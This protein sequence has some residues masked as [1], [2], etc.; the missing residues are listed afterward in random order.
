[1]TM[2]RQ[3]IRYGLRTLARSPGFAAVVVLILAVGIGVNTAIFSA[4]NAVLLRPLSY[5][6]PSRIVSIWRQEGKESF[7]YFWRPEFRLLREQNQAFES[8]AG[9]SLRRVYLS[10]IDQPRHLHAEEVSPGLFPLL[11][12][13]PVL[14]RGFLPEEE[15]LGKEYVVILSDAFWREQFAGAPDAIGKTLTLDNKSYTIVGVMPPGFRFPFRHPAPFW[16]SMP[17]QERYG[18]GDAPCDILARLPEGSTLEQAQGHMAV[19]TRR[20]VEMDPKMPAYPLVLHRLT[21]DLFGD[22][23]R[24]LLLSFGAAGFLLL[25]ACSNAGNLLLARATLRR[26]EIAI[27]MAV[28]SSRWRILRQMLTESVVLSVAA[29]LLGLLAA[30]CATKGLVG[31]SPGDIPGMRETRVD[32][33]VLLF[34]L[35]TSLLT[36][37]VFGIVPAWKASEVHLIQV[38]KGTLLQTMTGR[39]WRWLHGGLIISQIS[40]SVILLA[41]CGLLVRSLIAMQNADLG[42]QPQ[43]MLRVFIELPKVR[44]PEPRHCK[45]FYEQLLER[46]QHLPGVQAAGL[47]DLGWGIGR[48][49]MEFTVEGRPSASA[50]ET[51]EV[52]GDHVSLGFF[53]SMGMQLLAGRTLTEQDIGDKEVGVVIDEKLARDFFS[54]VNPLGQRIDLDRGRWK[55]TIVGVVKTLRDFD[56]LRPKYGKVYLPPR[57]FYSSIMDLVVRTDGDPMRLAGAVR[58]EISALDKELTASVIQTAGM[59]LSQMLAPQ[60]FHT[61]LIGLSAGIALA[62]A[63][64]GIYGLMAFSTSQRTG[65][66][67]IRM[68]FGASRGD[69]LKAVVG[70]GL[71]LALIGVA[72]GL[73]GALALTR[74]LASLLYDTSTMD[75]LT[76]ALVSVV[77]IVVALLASYLPARRAARIDPMA[78][79]RYE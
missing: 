36:G 4:V 26:R 38:V 39:N 31:L 48:S 78:A 21:D 47:G 76:F 3:D 79:L 75:P 45:A 8:L 62:L 16:L 33:S 7:D 30:F 46:V 22:Y 63:A 56:R 20:L 70:Q 67:G 64:A 37:L 6:E 50:E 77:L 68:A 12:V 69:I 27:R 13:R 2:L 74:V 17:V 15:E 59:A 14:G 65:E 29:G 40:I 57:Q 71:K 9:H 23:R 5:Q 44:Y 55:G 41:G 19:M 42:F 18:W 10:G 66:I 11:G 32:T 72:V 35:G 28:G 43:G 60:R 54:G 25:I 51:L 52:L 49:L 73:A 1:M 24:M 58:A 34:A 53:D 61:M